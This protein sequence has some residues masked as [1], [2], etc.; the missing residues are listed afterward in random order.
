M[1]LKNK[2]DA[3][4]ARARRACE[5]YDY[6]SRVDLADLARQLYVKHI[7]PNNTVPDAATSRIRDG[8]AVYF[9]PSKPGVRQRFSLAH[10]LAHILVQPDLTGADRLEKE[11]PEE[12]R[13]ENLCDQVAT[14]LLMPAKAVRTRLKIS[15]RS[16]NS[17]INLAK[18]FNVSKQAMALRIV[19]L[20]PNP[21]AIVYATVSEHT[22]RLAVEWACASPNSVF[23]FRYIPGGKHVDSISQ[24]VQA[25]GHTETWPLDNYIDIGILGFGSRHRAITGPLRGNHETGTAVM[26]VIELQH[27]LPLDDSK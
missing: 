25:I 26:S 19:S 18:H 1:I 17:V 8:Y 9:N 12:R 14:S 3:I 11:D 7:R 16:P 4:T 2:I 13:L 5:Y 21:Y 6:R 22:G 23:G 10:E 15:G 20:A 27:Q 24:F